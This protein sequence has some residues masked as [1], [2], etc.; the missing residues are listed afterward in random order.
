MEWPDVRGKAQ[1]HELHTRSGLP[2]W[3][4]RSRCDGESR[5][6]GRQE[7]PAQ[8]AEQGQPETGTPRA[9]RA[10]RGCGRTPCHQDPCF[11]VP[12]WPRFKGLIKPESKE[13][14][15]T[16]KWRSLVA[17]LYWNPLWRVFWQHP[18]KDKA[19][20]LWQRTHPNS[21]Q[22]PAHKEPCGCGL[23]RCL[24]Q[25]CL[26]WWNLDNRRGVRTSNGEPR[27]PEQGGHACS[28]GGN[29]G[30]AGKGA[31]CARS[32][33]RTCVWGCVC[34]RQARVSLK[35]G[36]KLRTAGSSREGALALISYGFTIYKEDFWL[37]FTLKQSLERKG[38]RSFVLGESSIPRGPPGSRWASHPG[39]QRTR[40][41]GS[42]LSPGGAPEGWRSDVSE[43]IPATGCRR[44]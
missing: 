19:W 1:S 9:R 20:L 27:S 41:S 28:Q 15:G 40:S 23:G 38:V 35:G 8:R 42:H 34:V 7:T 33:T 36:L 16:R 5:R 14:W 21:S 13:V 26:C 43:L 39:W 32:S 17:G 31:V 6:Q 18:I 3:T 37:L 4:L 22:R 11:H 30:Q 25:H 29:N 10:E 24:S 2:G 44:N 12:C